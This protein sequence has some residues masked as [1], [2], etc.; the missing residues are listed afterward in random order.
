MGG[1]LSKDA[2]ACRPLHRRRFLAVLVIIAVAC[3]AM[4]TIAACGGDED[5]ADGETTAAGGD[6]VTVKKI[7]VSF[8]NSSKE[9]A[10]QFELNFSKSYA[11]GL[12][13][14]VIVD[15]PGSDQNKQLNTVNTWIA[16][17]YPAMVVVALDA[18]PFQNIV[19]EAKEKGTSWVSYGA[20]MPGE[21]G[22]ID[23]NQIE[24]G[25]AIG[26]LCGEWI[27]DELGKKAKVAILT[28]EEG[29]WAR[30]RKDGIIQGLDSTGADYKIVAE[31]D[32]LSETEGLEK[33]ALMLQAN[34]D[35]NAV[36]AIEE[37]A[38]EG[39]YEAFIN[40]GHEKGDPNVFL[41]GIDGTIKALRLLDEGDTMYRGAAAL[42]LKALG[43]GLVDTCI[44]LAEGAPEPQVYKVDYVP[45]TPGDPEIRTFIDQWESKGL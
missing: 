34:P 13:W 17:G 1:H 7:G 41:G 27:N 32:A 2:G 42:D 25:V 37:T 5:P 12:G 36:L 30:A 28:Y 26:S 9:G 21:S 20:P 4:F 38:T 45:L 18:G 6:E 3:L 23:M 8:P 24:G 31:Q 33:T 43:E 11:E 44:A 15:D 19:P 14:E 10:V 16:E 35:L 40:A 22:Q 29:E 39:A